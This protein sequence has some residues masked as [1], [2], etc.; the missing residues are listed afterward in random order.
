MTGNCRVYATIYIDAIVVKVR[1]GQ[2]AN[3]PLYAA[4]G[5]SLD[6]DRDI[7]GPWAGPTSPRRRS[8]DPPNHAG[9]CRAIG[10]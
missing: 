9:R 5:V 3:R 6:G 4:I 10:R 7:L 2:V 1:D 8:T